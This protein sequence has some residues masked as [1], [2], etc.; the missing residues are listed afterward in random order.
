MHL[1]HP[2]FLPRVA[3]LAGQ[4]HLGPAATLLAP[5]HGNYTRHLVLVRLVGPPAAPFVIGPLE[6]IA[7][8]HDFGADLFGRYARTSFTLAV[9]ASPRQ[10]LVREFR[11]VLPGRLHSFL[12]RSQALRET[13]VLGPYPC[14][15]PLLSGLKVVAGRGNEADRKTARR[16][17]EVCR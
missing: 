6:R 11:R 16:C 15:P 14:S 13:L 2:H 17:L 10:P 8:G 7:R 1:H 3:A 12:D 5:S 9:H 4:G